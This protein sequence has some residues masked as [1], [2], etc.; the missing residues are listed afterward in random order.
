MPT[1]KLDPNSRLDFTWNFGDWMPDGDYIASF[2]LLPETGITYDGATVHT[3]PTSGQPLSAV[4][5]WVSWDPGVAAG[6]R[7]G[8]TCRIVTAEGREDDKTL[9]FLAFEG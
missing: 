3:S 1:K 7:L 8:I 2:E 5:A 6:T 9:Y 4:T